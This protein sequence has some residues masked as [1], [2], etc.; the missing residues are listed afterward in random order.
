[1][2]IKESR[3]A[4]LVSFLKQ[5]YFLW[6]M[7]GVIS[8]F[9]R[10]RHAQKG[11]HMIIK[12]SGVDN[13]EKA[14]GLIG[15]EVSWKS[16]AGKEIKGKIVKEHGRNGFVRAIFETGMPGQSVGSKVEVK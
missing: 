14:L 16:P 4:N 1:M 15:K 3:Y 8:N 6:A 5:I 12:V 9:R 13:K 7:E 10:S 2:A 11:S